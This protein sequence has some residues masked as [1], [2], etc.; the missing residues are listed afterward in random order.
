MNIN[1]PKAV[2]IDFYG[3]IAEEIRAPVEEIRHR[4]LRAAPSGISENEFMRC[5]TEEF[6]R[7]CAECN[8]PSFRLQRDIERLSLQHALEQF[9]IALES[10]ELSRLLSDYRASPQLFPESEKVLARCRIPV[11]LVSNIDNMEIRLALERTGLRFDCIVT[12]EDC[13]YYKPRREVF[14]KA[15]SLL[16][17]PAEEVL[18]AGDSL[19]S[20]IEGAKALGIKTLWI[21]RRQRSL[22]RDAVRPD[23]VSRDLEG[24][25]KILG[26]DE[27]K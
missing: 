12:S 3:T 9:S 8:G 18:H 6:L 22:V 10:K 27:V 25:L 15:L 26:M 5:W 17:V 24:L 7:L 14:E 20:D 1:R 23:Y 21:N 11:C 19:Q 16:G 13:R 4:I 2:L